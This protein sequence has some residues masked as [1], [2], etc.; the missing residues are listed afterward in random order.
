[1]LLHDILRE[2]FEEEYGFPIEFMMAGKTVDHYL[3]DGTILWKED[4]N[5]SIYE[6]GTDNQCCYTGYK[7]KPLIEENFDNSGNLVYWEVVG[8]KRYE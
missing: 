5:G 6:N 7:Y 2:D 3:N 8:F 1:M 4:F